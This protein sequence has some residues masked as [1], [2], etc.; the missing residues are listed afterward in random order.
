[1]Y[2]YVRQWDQDRETEDRMTTKQ[3]I[4]KVGDL[5]RAEKLIKEAAK[6][7]DRHDSSSLYAEV[8]H[9]ASLINEEVKEFL[10]TTV[11]HTKD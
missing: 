7:L 4:R 3:A 1:M 8:F 2:D 5:R 10:R 11:G 9:A 6:L